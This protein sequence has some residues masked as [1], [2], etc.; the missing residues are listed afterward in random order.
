MAHPMTVDILRLAIPLKRILGAKS[1]WKLAQNTHYHC[2]AVCKMTTKNTFY[3]NDSSRDMNF[4][5]RFGGVHHVA[6]VLGILQKRLMMCTVHCEPNTI[7]QL[8]YT[9]ATVVQ[10]HWPG[11]I[12]MCDMVLLQKAHVFMQW[13]QWT[14]HD[15]VMAW[16]RFPHC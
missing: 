6:T 3:A 13:T 2:R 9:K 14:L 1:I 16:K 10:I 11:Y 7:I 4:K 8:C 15:D 12:S 5:M